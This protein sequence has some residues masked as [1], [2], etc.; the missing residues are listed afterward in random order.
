LERNS[1]RRLS[2]L[3]NRLVTWWY[4]SCVEG[5]ELKGVWDDAFRRFDQDMRSALDVHPDDEESLF[6]TPATTILD[7]FEAALDAYDHIVATFP[8]DLPDG[9]HEWLPSSPDD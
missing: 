4:G 6:A 3:H 1:D 9:W 2:D 7:C 5:S 8:H